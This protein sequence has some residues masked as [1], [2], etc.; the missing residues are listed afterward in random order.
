MHKVWAVSA[1]ENW[2]RAVQFFMPVKR[3]IHW[4]KFPQ[5][6]GEKSAGARK[7]LAEN[8]FNS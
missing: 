2:T 4:A 3:T 7:V 1:Y 8:A 5:P 6:P